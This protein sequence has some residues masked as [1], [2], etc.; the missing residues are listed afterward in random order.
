M[1]IS[2]GPARA[3]S[4][5]TANAR[6]R[7]CSLAHSAPLLHL[8]PAVQA[9]LDL[10]FESAS[11]RF[12]V[13]ASFECGWQTRHVG[14]GVRLGMRVLVPLAVG[15]IFHEPGGRVAQMERYRFGDVAVRVFGGMS[16]RLV[17]GIALRCR[18]Q[19]EGG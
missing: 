18:G 13:A 16:V 19:I 1:C 3:R 9:P 5:R 6:S 10:A 4:W 14:H 12:V 7:T 15:E 2:P 17:D 11:A 8:F